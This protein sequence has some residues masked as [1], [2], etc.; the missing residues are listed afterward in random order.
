MHGFFRYSSQVTNETFE[1]GKVYTFSIYAQGDADS[2]LTGGSGWQSR[3]FLYI[4]DGS[5]PF[6]EANAL[7]AARYSPTDSINTGSNDFVNRDPV[8]TSVQSQAGWQQISISWTVQPGALEIGSPVGVGFYIG[9]D[10]AVDDASLIKTIPGDFDGDDD[11][12]GADFITWQINYPK[13]SNASLFNGDA[14]GDRDV[15]GADLAIWGA[16]FPSPASPGAPP[17]P[18]PGTAVIFV[19][20]L[21]GVAGYRRLTTRPRQ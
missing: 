18:E 19:S 2:V 14:D 1:A 7:K 17:V 15:D 20:A 16:N 21:I 6:S 8:W 3:V 13:S 4:F 11:V 10:G 5:E 9:D 12:D